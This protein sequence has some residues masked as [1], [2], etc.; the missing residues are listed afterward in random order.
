MHLNVDEYLD[1]YFSLWCNG[2]IHIEYIP[3]DSTIKW[4]TIIISVSIS[5]WRHASHMRGMSIINFV[6]GCVEWLIIHWKLSKVVAMHSG[7]LKF[8][9]W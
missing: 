6:Y 8:M 2:R 5:I 4:L 7:W 9:S 1:A 3:K